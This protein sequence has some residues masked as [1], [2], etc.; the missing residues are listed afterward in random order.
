MVKC[1]VYNLIPLNA[2]VD[3]FRGELHGFD[4]HS[5]SFHGRSIVSRRLQSGSMC[6]CSVRDITGEYHFFEGV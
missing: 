5:W 1:S 4:G 6:C 2:F 3:S